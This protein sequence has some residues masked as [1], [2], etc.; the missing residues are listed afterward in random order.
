MA[1]KNTAI[2]LQCTTVQ[3]K[4]SIYHFKETGSRDRIQVFWR[5][6]TVFWSKQEVLLVLKV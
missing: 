6:S 3:C 5:K 2:I 4:S 1:A